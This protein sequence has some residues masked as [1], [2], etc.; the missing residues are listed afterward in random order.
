MLVC[1]ALPPIDVVCMDTNV[2]RIKCQ[3]YVSAIFLTASIIKNINFR[4]IFLK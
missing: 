1:V 2:V 4:N 3:E